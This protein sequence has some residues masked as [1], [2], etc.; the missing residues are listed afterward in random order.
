MEQYKNHEERAVDAIIPYLFE[1]PNLIEYLKVTTAYRYQTIED[2]LW[3]IWSQLD[4]DNA[5]GVWLDYLALKVGWIESEGD[6]NEW[7]TLGPTGW[8]FGFAQGT[9]FTRRTP[10]F[11]FLQLP[12]PFQFGPVG[13]G[14]GFGTGLFNAQND[15]DINY[16]DEGYGFRQ[17][18]FYTGEDTG[19]YNES[20]FNDD[21]KR[22]LIRIQIAKNHSS[23]LYKE[24]AY[25]AQKLTNASRVLVTTVPPA[26]IN[27]T[28]Y[29]A[30][31]RYN[32][33]TTW[34]NIEAI[35]PAGVSLNN[36]YYLDGK[37]FTFGR[38][39]DGYGFDGGRFMTSLYTAST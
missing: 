37:P 23:G 15:P 16:D 12:K 17:G 38:F 35:L 25:I 26:G 24:V 22:D 28:I 14:Y 19:Y 7:F 1:F 8:G 5:T 4:L 27:L 32:R 21:Q 18:R 20:E 34:S 31:L 36:V 39:E 2:V 13:T 6:I 30:S 10:W 9:F 11:Q 33:D 29:G 3:Y